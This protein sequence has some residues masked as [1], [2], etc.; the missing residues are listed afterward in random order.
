[1]QW[2]ETEK[3][4]ID[5]ARM[6]K[7]IGFGR[8]PALLIIDMQVYMMGDKREP[9]LKSIERYPSSCGEMAWDAAENIRRLIDACH[10]KNF[11]V[12][13]TRMELRADGSD[14]GPFKAKR[15][16]LQIDNWM[17]EGTSGAAIA[18]SIAPEERDYV[19]VKKRPSAFFGTP[20]AAYLFGQ[21]V[22][23]L[24]VTGGST[25]SCVRATVFDSASYGYHTLVASDALCDRMPTSHEVNLRDMDR[26]FA[27]VMTTRAI[28]EGLSKAE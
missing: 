16:L 5:K 8:K 1:M 24:I 13:Y 28:L 10:G 21:G 25:S 3:T 14:A 9:I 26:Q 7:K 23:T 12:V 18:P 27:D 11:P 2:S 4:I 22:D 15:D 19:F 20:L 6:G 17:L